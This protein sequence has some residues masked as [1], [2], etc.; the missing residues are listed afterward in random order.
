VFYL[1]KLWS[2]VPAYGKV[3]GTLVVLFC[4]IVGSHVTYKTAKNLFNP[5]P[6]DPQAP[7]FPSC[8]ADH[9]KAVYYDYTAANSN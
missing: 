9:K 1:K 2:T 8:D 4:L 7:E 3:A 6:V 5:D